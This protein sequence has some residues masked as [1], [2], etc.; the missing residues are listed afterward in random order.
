MGGLQVG[1]DLCN[2]LVFEHHPVAGA[3]FA[4]VDGLGRLGGHAQFLELLGCQGEALLL[5]LALAVLV[6]RTVL[7]T[8]DSLAI[9]ASLT[10]LLAGFRVCCR[11]LG[12]GRL[13]EPQ[14][15]AD[16]V[17]EVASPQDLLAHKLK[18]LLRR[19]EP[20][21]YQ[22]IDALLASGL[23]LATGLGGA[24]ALFAAFAPQEC[25]K[26]LTYFD[27]KLLQD[28]P[29]QLKSRLVEAAEHV[30]SVPQLTIKAA[31]LSDR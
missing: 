15:T 8:C 9:L 25:L 5:L 24:K 26:A 1:N 4:I 28:L 14:P 27:D 2:R 17:L 7:A 30:R 13:E 6:T 18:V 21:D 22:D 3:L 12:F 31:T 20:K 11:G 16:G 29:R 10:I 23:D 19:V